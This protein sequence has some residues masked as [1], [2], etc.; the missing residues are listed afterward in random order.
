[1]RGIVLFAHGSRDA[2]WRAPIEA[3][4]QAISGDGSLV[5]CAYLEMTEPDLPAACADLIAQGVDAIRVVPMFL[6]IGKHVRVDLPQ[7]LGKLRAEHASVTFDQ[8]PVIGEHPRV[9]AALAQ[10]ASRS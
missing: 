6:G 3:V 5:R 10:V 9:I 1:M 4:A 2:A 8:D 7:L